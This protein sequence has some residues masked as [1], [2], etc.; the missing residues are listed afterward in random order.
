MSK[1]HN[2][3]ISIY[4]QAK[5]NQGSKLNKTLNGRHRIPTLLNIESHPM[6]IL[7]TPVVRVSDILERRENVQFLRIAE[8]KN[9]R[10]LKGNTIY[11]IFYLRPPPTLGNLSTDVF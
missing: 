8:S 10:K 2:V 4:F 9:V 3:E 5:Q 1:G 6:L 11:P 7:F